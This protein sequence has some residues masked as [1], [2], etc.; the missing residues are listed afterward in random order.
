MID[1]S[2]KVHERKTA[3]NSN[4]IICNGKQ[5][6][7]KFDFIEKYFCGENIVYSSKGSLDGCKW[8]VKKMEKRHVYLSLHVELA[9]REL[10]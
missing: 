4:V 10:L 7:I 5:A 1:T 6:M 2:K 9:E 3:S 8:G